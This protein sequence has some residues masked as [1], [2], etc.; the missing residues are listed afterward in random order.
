MIISADDTAQT[1]M[2]NWDV[3]S[4]SDSNSLDLNVWYD[5]YADVQLF[6]TSGNYQED[7][8]ALHYNENMFAKQG[9]HYEQVKE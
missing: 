4:E 6:T 7:Y 9:Y 5:G 1:F 2:D 8:Y 3:S